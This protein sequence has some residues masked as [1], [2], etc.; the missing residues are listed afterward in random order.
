MTLPQEIEQQ[1]SDRKDELV[2]DMKTDND[3]QIGYYQGFCAGHEAGATEWA[4]KAE[5][6][7]DAALHKER[8]AMQAK[9]TGMETKYLE[10]IRGLVDALNEIGNGPFPINQAEL[11]EWLLKTKRDARAALAKYKEVENG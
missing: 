5:E 4:G 7:I 8:N 1:I 11:E 6:Q 9:I 2:K 10:Q 3:R